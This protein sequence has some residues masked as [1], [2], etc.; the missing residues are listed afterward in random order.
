MA[1]TFAQAAALETDPVRRGA[2]ETAMQ[3]SL[4]WDRLP[5]ESIEGNAYA[6]DKDKVLPGTAFRTVNE[7][8]VASTGVIN[9]D[10]ERLTI[11]GGDAAVDQLIEKTM[12]SSRGV[13]MADQVR[14]KLESA[15][16]TYVDTMFNGDVNVDP[17][18]FDGLRKRLTGSQ[19]ID[20]TT[21][22]SNDGFLDELDALFGQVSGGPDVVYGPSAQIARLKSLGRK[23]GGA[24]YV[25]SEITGKRE[26]TWNGV[27]FIDPGAHW[28]GRSF[29]RVDPTDGGDFYAVKFANGFGVSGV[30]GI[31][32]GGLQAYY[33]GELQEKPAIRTRID[34]YTG[35]VVQGGKAA[36]RLRGVKN[37]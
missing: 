36:A 4:V 35:L 22:T 26:F 28:S 6:Y 27:P 9:Q 19:V 34:F 5:F 17:K 20:S 30:M 12:Q 1:V 21:L 32:N 25:M 29:L 15:Q 16:A 37:A 13:L 33:L 3:V 14:M 31:T 8:Y 2:I 10:Q 23:V 24:E 11:L 18:G 7:A